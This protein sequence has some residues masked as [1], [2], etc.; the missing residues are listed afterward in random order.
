MKRRHYLSRVIFDSVAPFGN[1][2]NEPSQLKDSR[3]LRRR[4]RREEVKP[5]LNA[6]KKERKSK[7]PHKR[8]TRKA[9][10]IAPSSL[11]QGTARGL[12]FCVFFPRLRRHS[13]TVSV[14]SPN[15]ERNP[16]EDVPKRKTK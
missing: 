2:D 6:K 14:N 10:A 12:V 3:G 1:T 5:R 13:S 7:R 9:Y 16:S 8:K 11:T 4:A 15:F